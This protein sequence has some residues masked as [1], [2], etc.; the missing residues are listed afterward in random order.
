MANNTFANITGMVAREALAIAHE[1]SSFLGT[2]DLQYDTEYAKTGAK[3]GD[4]LKVR[5]PNKYK[6]RTGNAIDVQDQNE[7]TGT[8]TL[9]TLKGVDMNFSTVDLT[10]KTDDRDQVAAFSKRY[11]QP[12]MAQ[13]IS[14]IEYDMLAYCTKKVYQVAGT[15][16]SAINS[17]STPNLARAKLN[18]QAA[19]KTDRMVQMD[20]VSMSSLVAGA[21]SYFAPGAD[22]GS[23][24]REG[25][26]KRT[27]MADFYEN[28]RCWTLTNG[29]DVAGEIN[30]GTISNGM[31]TITVDG[32]TA[33]PEV[34]AVF[35]IGSGS[36]ETRVYDVHPETKQAY[37]HLKQFTVVSATTT[38]ITFTPAIY[39]DTTDARQN[40]SG[41]PA[42]NADIV[43]IGNAST[44]YVQPL[45]YHK[46]AFQFVTADLP[47]LGGADK[48]T[49]LNMDGISLRV[50]MDGDIRNNALLCR[51]DLLHGY[52]ALRPEWAC[53]M[54]GAAGV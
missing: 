49:R 43:F 36:G 35:T 19:P 24:Y 31:T 12:A 11:I 33:A 13:L 39:Y 45:M 9:A 5:Y 1:Q 20:S 51:I 53:R 21:A 41:I 37:A 52:E 46:D 16:G 40:V 7:A 10:L 23:Q 28:E 30:G 26:V 8:I 29:A 17:L 22:I 42:D 4:S 34:G 18:Q 2:V 44:S 25:L 15:A 50:W 47:L 38:S 48:C 6:T 54:I 3:I 32:F 14:E 27:A